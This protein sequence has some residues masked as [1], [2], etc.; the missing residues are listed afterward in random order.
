[1]K[2][3]HYVVVILE[4]PFLLNLNLLGKKKIG[5]RAYNKKKFQK[6]I[7]QFK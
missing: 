4:F 7:M 2:I 5:E 1:M 6:A 3:L